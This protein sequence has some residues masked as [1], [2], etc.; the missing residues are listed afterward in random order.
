MNSDELIT[1]VDA[2]RIIGIKVQ[3]LALW[4]CYQSVNLPFYRAEDGKR[5]FYK[6][7]EVENFS[8]SRKEKLN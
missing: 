7:A 1:P 8:K 4:R 5:V 3:T 2:A 6:K